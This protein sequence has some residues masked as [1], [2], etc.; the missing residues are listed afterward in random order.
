V[1]FRVDSGNINRE[2]ALFSSIPL[3]LRSDFEQASKRLNAYY[4][5]F[6]RNAIG[7]SQLLDLIADLTWSLHLRMDGPSLAQH[8]AA[9]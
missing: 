3:G 4:S 6:P 2:K 9:G 7:I 1:P 5:E 8:T